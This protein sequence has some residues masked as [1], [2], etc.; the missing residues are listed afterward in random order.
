MQAQLVTIQVSLC[1][2]P[3]EMQQAVED[4]LKEYGQPTCWIVT[5]VDVVQQWVEVEALV[6]LK[7]ELE[8]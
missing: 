8:P 2:T 5:D 4:K 7:T 3:C 6:N 1:D